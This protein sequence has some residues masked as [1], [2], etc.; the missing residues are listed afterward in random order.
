MTSPARRFVHVFATFGAGGPQVRAVQLMAQAG[1]GCRHVVLAMDGH[2]EAKQQLPAGVHVEFAPPPKQ[3]G[4]LA[5][6]RHQRRWLAGQAPDLVLTYNWGAIESVL[7]ARSLRLPLVHHEDGFLPDEATRRLRRRNWLRA[8]ALRKVPVIVPSLVLKDIA[9]REWR[10]PPGN[11]HHLPNGVDLRR[12]APAAARDETLVGTVGGLR[13]EKDH[14]GL[15]RAFAP[16]AGA[17]KLRIVGGGPLDGEL[18]G[19]AARLALGARVEFTGPVTDTAP[20]YPRFAVFVLSSRTE[21]MPIA[22]LEA[23]ACGCAVVATA[24]GDVRTILPEVAQPFVVPPG[25]PEALTAALRTVLADGDLRARLGAAN[26]QRV[27]ERYEA[28]TC[29]DRFTRVYAA[30]QQRH[31]S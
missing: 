11:V 8:W 15:L 20:L 29:L 16:L 2:E 7:A 22:L 31:G 30:A 4:L 6:V 5:T 1:D 27:E 3:R 14:S 26:R 9:T 17:A 28:G 18:R 13:A 25:D 12:F 24:V 19:L 23:M 21:Q 10:L